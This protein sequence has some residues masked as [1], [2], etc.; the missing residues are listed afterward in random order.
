MIN[1]NIHEPVML[2]E[3]KKFIPIAKKLMLLMPL[4]VEGAIQE[5]Y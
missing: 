3:I 1:V 4:L 2:E 5:R